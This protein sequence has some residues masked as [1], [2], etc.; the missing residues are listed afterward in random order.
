MAKPDKDAESHL[1]CSNDWMNSQGI[2]EEEKCAWFCLT[3][4]GDAHLWYD[5]IQLTYN[6]WLNL[7]KLFCWQFSKLGHTQEELLCRWRSFCFDETADIIDS[8]VLRLK[9]CAQMLGYNEGQVLE[10]FKNILP[11][12]Y[13]Y[14]FFGI[15][16]PREAVKSAKW[17]MTKENVYN[18]LACLSSISYMSLKTHPS[19]ENKIVKFDEYSYTTK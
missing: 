14:L 18:K 9:Q 4:V 8:Y 6:D 12:K 7:Q 1:L 16:N 10:L 5:P 3:L 13:Y 17:V 19:T 15:Q 2:V 11:N